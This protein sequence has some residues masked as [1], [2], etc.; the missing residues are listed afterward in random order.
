MAVRGADRVEFLNRMLTQDLKGLSPGEVR[1]G[2]LLNRKGRIDADVT[3]A[4]RPAGAAGEPPVTLL[5]VDVHDAARTASALGAMVFFEDVEVREESGACARRRARRR[6]GAS[7]AA[8]RPPPRAGRR[9]SR[10]RRSA[11]CG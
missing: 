10:R 8:R 6:R 4:D 1:C 3:V 9:P 7:R 5:D 11:P 2:F